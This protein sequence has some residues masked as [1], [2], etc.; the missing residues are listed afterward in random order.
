MA[1]WRLIE[2]HYLGV[3]G[4]KW[5]YQETDR[6]TGRQVRKS[7]P[8]PQHFHPDTEADWT[9]RTGR[10]MGIVVVS[11]GHNAH[12]TDIVFKGDPTPGML[13]LDDE[14]TAISARFEKKWLTPNRVFEEAEGT[15]ASRQ[16][17]QYV[18][19]QGKVNMMLAEASS[20]SVAGMPEFMAAMTKI[21]EQNQQIMITL[22]AREM[23][24]KQEVDTEEP[25][26]HALGADVVEPEPAPKPKAK[27][28]DTLL[29]QLAAHKKRKVA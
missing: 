3:E 21:M 5:E 22:A 19:S 18:E 7:F 10:D 2:P 8:V 27:S 29:E 12:K 25:L 28:V 1:R 20:R 26:P 24:I 17:D 4:V 6:M 23:G 9:E 14:A 11:D 13:P 16:M 15:Y